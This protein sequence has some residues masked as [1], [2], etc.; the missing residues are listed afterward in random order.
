M[1]GG[2]PG[3][4]RAE[5]APREE[6]A[7]PSPLQHALAEEEPEISAAAELEGGVDTASEVTA[8]VEKATGLLK[9]FA[10]GRFELGQLD[11]LLRSFQRR[12]GDGRF[13]DAIRLARSLVTLLLLAQRWTDLVRTLRMV[14]RA[15][16]RIGD[17]HA[18]AWAL[19][20]L[21]TLSLGADDAE[22]ATRQLERARELRREIGDTQGLEVTEHNLRLLQARPPWYRPRNL[23]IAGAAGAIVAVAIALAI[24]G[25]GPSPTTATSRLVAPATA[26]AT[27]ATKSATGTSTNP[28]PKP[29][30]VVITAPAN[31][32]TTGITILVSGTAGTGDQDADTVTVTFTPVPGTGGATLPPS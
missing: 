6:Q 17:T 25:P 29:P 26:A 7:D 22:A 13:S 5:P 3:G 23:A 12:Y 20:E 15:A 30:R 16:E 18:Q 28:G 19:H 31:G 9:S 8:E 21:G 11:E 27:S 32:S 2:G 1:Y 4:T 14:R 24:P 10:E